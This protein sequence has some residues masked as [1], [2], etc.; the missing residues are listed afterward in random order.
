MRTSIIV[1]CTLLSTPIA[2]Q[3][4]ESIA[5][6]RELYVAANY[7]GALGV[8]SRLD[9]PSSQP[10]DRMAINQYR[11]FCL[12]ALG[13]TPEAEQ[14]IEAVVTANPLYRP[15]D[16][17]A[18][19]RLQSAFVTVRKRILPGLVQRE[20]TDAKAAFDRQDYPVA[21]IGFD[22][23]LQGL[24]DPDLG[25]AANRSPLS[26][27]RTL[28]SG[29]RD[30]SARAAAPPPVPAPPPAIVA[31]AP[32]PVVVR[33]DIYSGGEPGLIPPAIVSQ[34]LPRYS[35]NLGPISEGMLEV[36]VDQNGAVESAT[37]RVSVNPRYDITLLNAAKGWKYRPATMDGAPVKFRK[38]IKVSF[39]AQ[40]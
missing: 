20:Y 7:E 34:V 13:R 16:A 19:P 3:G 37:M 35:N 22:R 26:D 10:S 40:S 14:A 18:S 11:A 38:M 36:V 31:A 30:L 24:D 32:A 27:L 39:K 8:L 15:S 4:Q 6:A 21:L 17:E 25:E 9:S 2:S 33:K 23:T 12:L 28:A 29:F 1:I 5:A